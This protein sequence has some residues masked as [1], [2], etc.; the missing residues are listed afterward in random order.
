M[1]SVEENEENRKCKEENERCKGKRTENMQFRTFFHF[2]EPLKLFAR[3]TKMK[4][5]TGQRLKSHRET[6][7]AVYQNENFY[8][9]K[10]K[11]TPG[12]IGKSDSSPPPPPKKNFPVTPLPGWMFI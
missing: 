12:K 7:S 11:I 2:S 4:I 6:F 8:R 3:S 10:A 9:E 5:S 1:E